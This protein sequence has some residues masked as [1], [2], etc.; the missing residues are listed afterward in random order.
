MNKDIRVQDCIDNW[1]K[2]VDI[3][4]TMPDKRLA[5]KL[6]TVYIQSGIAVR[7]KMTTDLELLDIWIRQ[8]IEARILKAEKNIPDTANEIELAIADIE[9]VTNKSEERQEILKEYT[10]TE[11]QSQPKEKTQEDKDS[12]LKL[13]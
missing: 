8:I 11:I 5:E 13:F 10:N 2:Y 4:T 3:L 7:K 12:Q 6:E 9:T 1:D